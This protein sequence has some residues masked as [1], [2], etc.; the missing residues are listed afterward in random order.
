MLLK[1]RPC[2]A[3]TTLGV[4]GGVSE[5]GLT[6][7]G[8]QGFFK[9]LKHLD[10]DDAIGALE[11]GT[12]SVKRSEKDCSSQRQERGNWCNCGLVMKK[13]RSCAELEKVVRED[14]TRHLTVREK[15]LGV[16]CC[17]SPKTWNDD[18]NLA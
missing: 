17:D 4:W 5:A 2:L 6:I 7:V 15:E 3:S 10:C 13:Q 1:T 8:T 16:G 9:K 11:I 14:V 12:G 18:A